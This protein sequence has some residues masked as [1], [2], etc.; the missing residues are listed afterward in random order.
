MLACQLQHHSSSIEDQKILTWKFDVSSSSQPFDEDD[1]G[2][3]DQVAA[4]SDIVKVDDDFVR[5]HP[6]GCLNLND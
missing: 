5:S 2:L 6:D 4:A 3:V 1:I